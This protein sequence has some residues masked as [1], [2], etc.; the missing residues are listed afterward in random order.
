MPL[1]RA[2][3]RRQLACRCF[4]AALKLFDVLILSERRYA[5]SFSPALDKLI[6]SD[7][8]R[9]SKLN[10]SACCSEAHWRT[11][12]NGVHS[13]RIDISLARNAQQVPALL[14]LRHTPRRLVVELPTYA[15]IERHSNDMHQHLAKS[16]SMPVG[17]PLALQSIL[18]FRKSYFQVLNL[19]LLLLAARTTGGESIEG[20]SRQ[21]G[22]SALPLANIGSVYRSA[23]SLCTLSIRATASRLSTHCNTVS[24]SANFR[25]GWQAIGKAHRFL[26]QNFGFPG[27]LTKTS[28]CR[29][30]RLRVSLASRRSQ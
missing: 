11:G 8:P 17:L 29:P 28:A 10:K 2:V 4:L 13:G 18:T 27:A 24:V 30:N 20:R 6:S 3:C 14:K 7:F 16:S 23:R 15:S 22:P 12:A 19:K 5:P 21:T 25:S 1:S 9:L 26:K